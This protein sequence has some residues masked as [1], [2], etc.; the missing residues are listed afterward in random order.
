MKRHLEHIRL[1]QVATGGLQA[2]LGMGIKGTPGATVVA[3]ASD[4]NDMAVE[5]L[6]S[7]NP[8]LAAGAP[9]ADLSTKAVRTILGCSQMAVATLPNGNASLMLGF[10]A[11][12]VCATVN[13]SDLRTAL[14]L[15][16]SA[17]S[18]SWM[19]EQRAD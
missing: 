12:T 8:L 9:P 19:P 3:T 13:A 11:H 7:G 15:L 14:R 6:A 18:A 5:L 17:A 16:D 2:D 4:I 10:G 1:L